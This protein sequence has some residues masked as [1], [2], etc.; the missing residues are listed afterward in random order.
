M[1]PISLF[2][3]IGSLIS[4]LVQEVQFTD[5]LV[6]VY[7]FMF[8]VFLSIFIFSLNWQPIRLKEIGQH[9]FTIVIK[10][11]HYA[12]EFSSINNLSLKA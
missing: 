2:S 9:F 11:N 12:E 1:S 5:F 4:F 3:G 7:F 6:M 10:D 8:I